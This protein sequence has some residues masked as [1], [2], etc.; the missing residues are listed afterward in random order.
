MNA[1][2]SWLL[3]ASAA[4][5]VAFFG[6]DLRPALAASCSVSGPNGNGN[7]V[8]SCS[9]VTIY[10]TPT[11]APTPL[12][13]STGQNSSG[14]G[15][16]NGHA[17]ALFVSSSSGGSGGNGGD[18]GSSGSFQSFNTYSSPASIFTNY[19]FG[20]GVF[21]I[22]N[23]GNGGNGGSGYA[24]ASGSGGGN[25]G[26]GGNIFATILPAAIITEG[27]QSAGVY[28]LS[29]GGVG[30][31][32]GGSYLSFGGGGNGAAGGNGGTIDLQVQ[33][34][35][36]TTG[37]QSFGVWAQSVGGGGGNG[38]TSWAS[39]GGGGGGGVGQEGGDVTAGLLSGASILTMGSGSIGMLVQSIGGFGGNGGSS[40]L[41]YGGNGANGGIGGTV[42]VDNASNTS[43]VTLGNDAD[44]IIAE[45]VGGGGGF[46]GSSFG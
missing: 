6:A 34:N 1:R 5:A 3:A 4:V 18:I 24:G 46:G 31:N 33:S 40:V 25:G 39:V 10:A 32:G 29:A 30:G 44:A 17:G 28:A 41:T 19:T 13:G 42:S 8:I 45:S 38:G 15:G 37:T 36:Y 11:T 27:Y 12:F 21:I 16:G 35:I 22:S 2:Q 14:G 9:G 23:G 26:N 7:Y 43:I 20:Q